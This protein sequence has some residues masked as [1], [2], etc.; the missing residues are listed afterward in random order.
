MAKYALHSLESLKWKRLTPPNGRDGGG[1]RAFSGP[2]GGEVTQLPRE[3]AWHLLVRLHLHPVRPQR[4][5]SWVFTW[6]KRKPMS[7]NAYSGLFV[8]A[9]KET[10][11]MPINRRAGKQLLHTHMV[12]C[13]S[14]TGR[15]MTP[16]TR[17]IPNTL[18]QGTEARH[19]DGQ[20]QGLHL[21]KTSEMTN[22]ISS[23]GK[24]VS[25]GRHLGLRGNFW[26]DR[27]VLYLD[28]EGG[29]CTK[30]YT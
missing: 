12:G 7:T 6:E 13:Y 4:C 28:C 18:R 30:L 3:T 23:D 5:Q 15:T 16:A 9:T 8:R 21:G 22:L 14:S 25:G 27:S 24:Y 26:G 2:R 29:H 19:K 20:T 17:Q 11:R 1:T 10:T